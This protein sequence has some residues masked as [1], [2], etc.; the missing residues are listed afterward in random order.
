MI[1]IKSESFVSEKGK[2]EINED[3][4]EFESEKF[5]IVCDGLGGNGNGH[6]ASKLVVKTV[7]ESLLKSKSI[8]EAVQDAE[9]ILSSY[10]KKNHFTDYMATTI[11]VAEILDNEILVSW[12]GDSR[13]YQFRDGKILYKTTDHSWV[14]DAVK[15][16]DLSHLEALFHPRAN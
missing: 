15:K 14:A 2:R 6:I 1:T 5:Y 3:C 12:A 10:K 9:K 11:A 13:V 7:K 4:I 8:S 16:G